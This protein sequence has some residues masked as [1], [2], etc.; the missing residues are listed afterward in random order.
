MKKNPAFSLPL[1]RTER[2]VLVFHSL[3]QTFSTVISI[4]TAG[5][6]G[7]IERCAHD[8]TVDIENVQTS[9]FE[10]GCCIVRACNEELER[11]LA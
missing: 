11:R 9:R 10:M 7:E 1:R 2:K 8:T 3:M 6:F 4:E 5:D